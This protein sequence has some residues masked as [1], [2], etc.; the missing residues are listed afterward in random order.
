M[1]IE[2][3]NTA[4]TPLQF[5]RARSASRAVETTDASTRR[6]GPSA[7]FNLASGRQTPQPSSA[8]AA[9]DVLLPPT[10]FHWTYRPVP[11]KVAAKRLPQVADSAYWSLG[12]NRLG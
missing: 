9:R 12:L 4:M 5:S 1:S 7:Q 2:G 6:A 10:R 11:G 3:V 8:Q